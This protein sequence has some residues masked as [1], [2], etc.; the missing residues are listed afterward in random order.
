M[1][2]DEEATRVRMRKLLDPGTTD[3]V[4]RDEGLK[5][6]MGTDVI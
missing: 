1:R 3:D 4:F 2:S 5:V 6:S